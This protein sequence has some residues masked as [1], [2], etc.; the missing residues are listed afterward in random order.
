MNDSSPRAVDPRALSND[1]ER[2]VPLVGPGDGAGRLS[3]LHRKKSRAATSTSTSPPATP[4]NG[5]THGT[6]A[7]IILNELIQGRKH[8]WAKLY[9]PSRVKLARNARIPEGEHQ[10]RRTVQGLVHGRRCRRLSSEIKPGEGAVL[11]TGRGKIA[12]Y[13]DENG[14]VHQH[15][16]GVHAPLLHRPLERHRENL[17]LSVP[18]IPI[19]P[20]RQGRQRSRYSRAFACS[21]STGEDE[22]RREAVARWCL[23][24]V[25]EV[26]RLR[27]AAFPSTVSSTVPRSR[28]SGFSTVISYVDAPSDTRS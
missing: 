7:G 24:V 19:R 27:P 25:D 2:A 1:R 9:D 4:G 22:K 13:R 16:S 18:W 20:L 12:V 21:L 6:I 23:P 8:Q 14:G 26:N 11:G 5:M 10:R 15:V 3:G 28:P 17:G